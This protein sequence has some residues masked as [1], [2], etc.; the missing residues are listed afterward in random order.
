MGYEFRWNKWN[1]EH[2]ATHGV[3]PDEAEY[4]VNHPN[5]GYPQAMEDD[6]YLA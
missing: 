5:R 4:I 2:I 6:K 3:L 1:V